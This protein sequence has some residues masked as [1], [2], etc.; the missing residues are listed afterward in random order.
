MKNNTCTIKPNGLGSFHAAR[1]ALQK[2][3]QQTMKIDKKY[4]LE[5][6]ASKDR[7]K[8]NSIR[9]EADN[10]NTSNDGK[11]IA[12]DG[13]MLAVVPVDLYGAD[14]S[15]PDSE[16]Q[17]NLSVDTL[18]AARRLAG[19]AKSGPPIEITLNGNAHLS[20]GS[21]HPYAGNEYPN[22][23]CLVP[24]EIGKEFVISLSAKKL[25]ALSEAIGSPDHVTLS[26][27]SAGEVIHVKGNAQSG[28][29]FGLLMPRRDN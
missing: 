28:E 29:A 26:F 20:D 5:K 22:W 15:G 7:P 18:K 27:N 2:R 1:D 10:V 19:G 8:I 14:F 23:K 9:I 16:G 13:S 25:F 24:G 12:T 4:K 3:K 11:A 17:A 6:A 21:N